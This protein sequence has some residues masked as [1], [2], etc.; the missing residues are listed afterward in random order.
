MILRMWLPAPGSV[1]ETWD[2]VNERNEYFGFIDFGEFIINYR[3]RDSKII[4]NQFY[5]YIVII[6]WEMSK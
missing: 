1:E 3:K 6:N 5:T 4:I 2:K